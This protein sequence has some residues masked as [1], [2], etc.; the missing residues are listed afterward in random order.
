M[1]RR[2]GTKVEPQEAVRRVVVQQRDQSRIVLDI[3]QVRW[4]DRFEEVRVAGENLSEC[5]S[6]TGCDCQDHA[7][8]SRATA[9][10]PGI[11]EELD[12]RAWCDAAQAEPPVANGVMGELGALELSHWDAVQQV[13]RANQ[14]LIG[15]VEELLGIAVFEP[16]HGGQRVRRSDRVDCRELG[17]A[18]DSCG[19]IGVDLVGEHHVVRTHRHPVVPSRPRIQVK[20][21]GERIVRPVP[22]VGEP[23]DEPVVANRVQGIPGLRQPVEEESGGH[24]V[25]RRD[26]VRRQERGDIHGKGYDE[27]TAVTDR[28]IGAAA[29]RTG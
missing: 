15:G 26:R 18:L 16:E 23:R 25:L 22:P 28:A 11:R 6:G 1:G 27:R 10:V 29:R 14:H 12:R 5:R 7:I 8:Q 24:H 19:R 13:R 4:R 9:V 2:S 20:H 17:R 21:D 3:G